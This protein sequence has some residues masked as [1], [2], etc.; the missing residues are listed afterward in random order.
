[1]AVLPTPNTGA[2]LARTTT[3]A[4]ALAAVVLAA[5][6]GK[7][8]RSAKPKVLHEVCGRP[9]LWYVLKAAM[10][11][12]PS[13]IVVVVGFGKEG[14]EAAVHSWDL[15]VEV[16]FVDQHEA[17][18]TGHAVMVVEAAVGAASEVLVM[19]GDDPMPTR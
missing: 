15:G 12:R 6:K 14:V 18:G 4:R 13:R 11:A 16:V 19:A 1:M 2:S 5:G 7:R 10:A 8:M 17:L 3:S 9:G